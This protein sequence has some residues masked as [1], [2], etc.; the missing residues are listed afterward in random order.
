MLDA[1]VTAIAAIPTVPAISAISAVVPVDGSGA[2]TAPAS[3][4]SI[5]A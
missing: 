2:A 4:L 5:H 1:P 3:R